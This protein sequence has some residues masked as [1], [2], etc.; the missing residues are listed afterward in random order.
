MF[1]WQVLSDLCE[2][3]L[4]IYL[5]NFGYVRNLVILYSTLVIDRAYHFRVVGYTKLI[6]CLRSCFQTDRN[7][8]IWYYF[9][10]VKTFVLNAV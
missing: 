9:H 1:T 10:V 6:R 5:K 3:F 4:Q 8:C 2:G 7:L